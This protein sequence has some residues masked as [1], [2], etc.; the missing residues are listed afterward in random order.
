MTTRVPA[1]VPANN[2]ANH[3]THDSNNPA[4]LPDG[5]RDYYSNITGSPGL[6]DAFR[7]LDDPTDFAEC[8]GCLA[9]EATQNFVVD[10]G[11]DEAYGAFDLGVDDFA[12]LLSS[13]RPKSLETRWIN[14]WSPERHRDL[15]QTVTSNY[16]VSARLQAMMVSEPDTTSHDMPTVSPRLTSVNTP[17]PEPEAEDKPGAVSL[18]DLEG[19]Y[20]Q[21]GVQR[22]GTVLSSV[23]G[24][25]GITLSQIV[26]KIWHF[27]SV[28]YGQRY[29]CLG[30]NS[31]HVVSGVDFQNAT[32]KPEGKRV[33]TWLIICDDG[34]VISIHENP[35]PRAPDITPQQ[36]QKALEVIR[37]NTNLVFSGISSQHVAS[38]HRNPLM[39]TY[40]RNFPN[41]TGTVAVKA[42][43]GPSLLFY[44]L[45]D[46][47]LS[48]YSLV[49]GREHSYSAALNKLRKR[50]LERAQVELIDDLHSLGRQLAVLK[51]IYQSYD[52]IVNRILKRQRL[53]REE[54]RNSQGGSHHHQHQ[55][56]GRFGLDF[57]SRG[58]TWRSSSF[59][60]TGPTELGGVQLS[61]AAIGRFERLL[62]RIRLYALSEIDECLTEKESMTFMVFNLI[63]VKDSQAVERL[64]R[65][66]ILLAKAT[67]LFLPVSLMTGYFSTEI[68]ELEGVYTVKQYWIAFAVL[69]V[70]SALVLML[71]GWATD[72]IEGKTIYVSFAK[73][74]YR[75]S[76]AALGKKKRKVG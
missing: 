5:A 17:E 33:W 60:E 56:A 63:A 14:I 35:F 51:R 6:W 58:D 43:E 54:I 34:T 71:Y 28:D 15:V 16:G 39:T 57:L 4:S 75:A 13:P 18:A 52:L 23:D 20:Q 11:N 74:F 30:Y 72:T 7:N 62:D 19:G 53:L 44:Y 31:L 65:T 9:N 46:N 8:R 47:W 21:G 41:E 67:I 70:L 59:D 22:V 50:M 55:S 76:R 38:E 3:E 29:L 42:G 48:N 64:T 36:R 24:M 37:R 45:F 32:G 68:K 66:T 27:A 73:S 26:N 69:L 2:A 49:I 40:V 61:A 1:H 12:A 10:F 25:A